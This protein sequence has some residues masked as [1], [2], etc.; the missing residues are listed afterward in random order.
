MKRV[1]LV[2]ALLAAAAASAR[3]APRVSDPDW[4]CQQVKVP[5]LSVAALWTGPSVDAYRA[6]WKQDPRIAD[7]AGELSQ[8]RVPLDQAEADIANLA[9]QAGT[10]KQAKLLALFAG[11]FDTLDNERTSVIA[12]LSRF[13][14]RQKELAAELHGDEDAL[15]AAQ[16]NAT[17]DDAK[18]A[19]LT[20]RLAWD[21]QVF[22]QRRQSLSYAC[23]IPD[24]IEQRLF[25]LSRAI[26][27]QLG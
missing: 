13:G 10:E 14:H 20:Q 9:K 2:F 3:A 11:L 25:A 27:S 4:P 5:E 18:V 24:V 12:G 16:A 8:R 21:A 17:A 19:T 15:R 6:T 23:E 7:L 1:S 26:Q 22:E